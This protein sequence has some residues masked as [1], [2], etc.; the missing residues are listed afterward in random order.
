MVGSNILLTPR[1]GQDPSNVTKRRDDWM[2][3][4]VSCRMHLRFIFFA[5]LDVYVTPTDT[6]TDYCTTTHGLD[7][8]H[9]LPPAAVPFSTAKANV[10]E[11]LRDHIL[12]G[13]ALWTSLALLELTHPAVLTRDVATYSAFRERL[14]YDS[15]AGS[16]SSWAYPPLKDLVRVIMRRDMEPLFVNTTESA[17]AAMDLFRCHREVW[18]AVVL[19]KGWPCVILPSYYNHLY[20]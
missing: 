19:N 16:P 10:A 12:V 2:V 14:G 11:L 4:P 18:E 9:L 15:S 13:H 20:T 8:R 7:A 17:R 1:V 5:L 3:S 6:V